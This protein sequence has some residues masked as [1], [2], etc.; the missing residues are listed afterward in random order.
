MNPSPHF[1]ASYAEARARFVA[2]ARA[3]RAT[4]DSHVLA[5]HEGIDGEEL[6]IDVALF[7]AAAAPAMLIVTSATHGIEGYCGSGVQTALLD[8]DGFVR[9]VERDGVALSFVHGVNPYGFSHGRRVN[10]DNVD[11]NRNFRDFAKPLPKNAA[12]AGIHP[13]LVPATWPPPEDN[14]RQIAEYIAA[15][16]QRAFQAALTGGQ[17]EFPEG[18]FYGGAEP[19]WSNKTVRALLRGDAAKRQRLGFIDIHTG[20]GPR[21]HGEKIYAGRDTPAEFARAKRWWGDDVTSFYEGTSTSA[22][23]TG[24]IT[25]AAFD[26][27]PG[28]E[29]SAIGLEFGTRPLPEVFQALR[30]D[31]WLHLHADATPATRA[32]IEG[33]M[34][35][36][37]HDEADDWKATVTAQARAAALAAVT[38]LAAPTAG[39]RS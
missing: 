10:E 14:E 9:Q 33:A 38:G 18:L 15:H 6:A 28:A 17:Y 5:G 27:C 8:D 29:I 13:W 1:S 19:T 2:A 25:S 39:G 11:L 31:H 30:G 36:A 12:Y 3:R 37:F 32:M 23:V 34:R 7:G 20:L 4:L 26:E 35:R 24:L 16:G 22:N 21:G